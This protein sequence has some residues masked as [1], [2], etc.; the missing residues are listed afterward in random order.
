MNQRTNLLG[1]TSSAPT[2]AAPPTV[3]SAFW[4]ASSATVLSLLA[5]VVAVF[6]ATVNH[7]PPDVLATYRRDAPHATAGA[8]KSTVVFAQTV[9][10]GVYVMAA[11]I[12]VF[13]AIKM[14]A[15]RG[16]ARWATTALLLSGA[17][18]WSTHNLGSPL[19]TVVK[20]TIAACALVAIACMFVHRNRPYF[21]HGS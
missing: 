13:V 8:I 6:Q 7:V 2:V 4:L 18:L 21:Q 11:A 10:L 5:P 17:A 3:I 16:W 20:I 19:D 9:S 15:G 12:V 14:K 1:T